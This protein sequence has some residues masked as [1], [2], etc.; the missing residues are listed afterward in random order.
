MPALA[1]AFA[2]A[3]AGSVVVLADRVPAFPRAHARPS[4]GLSC[5]AALGLSM[6]CMLIQML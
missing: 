1:A 2:V 3:M 4:A 6:A 5:Q